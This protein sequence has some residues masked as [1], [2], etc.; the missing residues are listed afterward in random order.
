MVVVSS[1][2]SR[3]ALSSIGWLPSSSCAHLAAV[4]P[5][6]SEVD[7]ATTC[8]DPKTSWIAIGPPEHDVCIV[9]VWITVSGV[10]ASAT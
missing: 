7:R 9:M 8:N 10:A 5:A 4:P 6:K 2:T 1:R 3:L